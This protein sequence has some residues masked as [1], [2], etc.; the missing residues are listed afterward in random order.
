MTLF[1]IYQVL[2]LV[3]DLRL[4]DVLLGAIVILIFYRPNLLLQVLSDCS[5]ILKQCVDWS[6]RR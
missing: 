1:L 4:S 3:L 6:P 2:G 5:E